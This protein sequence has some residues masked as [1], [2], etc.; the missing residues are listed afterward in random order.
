MTE[1]PRPTGKARQLLEHMGLLSS[2]TPSV[3]RSGIATSYL[4]VALS[5]SVLFLFAMLRLK[6]WAWDFAVILASSAFCQWRLW[7]L[8]CEP[9]RNDP[10]ND[11]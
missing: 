8:A 5:P 6:L 1:T 10:P 9:K 3:R 7:S 4:V 11:S 2:R